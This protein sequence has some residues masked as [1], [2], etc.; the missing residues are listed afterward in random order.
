MRGNPKPSRSSS[1][2]GRSIP[3]YAG[4]PTRSPPGRRRRGVYPRVCGGTLPTPPHRA[5]PPGLSPRMRGNRSLAAAALAGGG[6]IPAYAGE[7]CGQAIT[8]GSG[9]VYPRVCGGTSPIASLRGDI[10]GL[11][12]RM[13]GNRQP[14]SINRGYCGSIPAYAGEP[15]GCGYRRRR[16]GVYPRVC[17]GTQP[18]AGSG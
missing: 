12:P 4:E 10:T 16:Q 14:L 2:S 7:P 11:S 8:A 9:R 1:W 3:A 5:A 17:G 15:W 18:A 13:R 6:S